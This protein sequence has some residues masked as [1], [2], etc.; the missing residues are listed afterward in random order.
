MRKNALLAVGSVTLVLAIYA[1]LILLRTGAGWVS[2]LFSLSPLLVAAMV[3]IV[4]RYDTYAG[5]ELEEEEE[6][7]YADLP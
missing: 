3:Y 1:L 7:G 6:F 2:L 5:K 4:I